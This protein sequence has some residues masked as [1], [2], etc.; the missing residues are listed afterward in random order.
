MPVAVIGQSPEMRAKTAPLAHTRAH[1][2]SGFLL[3]Q[4]RKAVEAAL[5]KPFHEEKGNHN[6]TAAAY[7]LPISKKDYLVAFYF[8]GKDS[9]QQ[10]KAVQLELT[11][12]EPSGPTGFFGLELGDSASKVETTLGKP[13]LI[14][15]EDDVNL[16]L[17]DYVENNYSLE[18][19]ADHKLYSIQIIDQ[20][21][22][23]SPGFAGSEEVRLFAQTIQ[24][25]DIDKLMELVSGEIECSTTEAFGIHAGSA[26]SILSN[27]KSPISLCLQRA[28]KA[29]L[30]LGPE[31]KGVDD[32]IRIWTKHTP[33]TVT[34]FPDSSPLKEVVFDQEAGAFRVYEVTFR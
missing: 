5:G 30:A 34:K 32:S 20:P 24:A 33:G 28:A 13:S 23:D 14:R 27:F 18:F 1:E 8:E 22:N 31:M 29:I 9:E 16:D 17:W 3:R 25:N 12:H 2:L 15:H 11:G 26:R 6:T 4:D 21:G 7:H 10:G 19:S